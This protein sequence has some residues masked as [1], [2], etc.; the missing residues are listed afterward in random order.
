[1]QFSL[2]SADK[3]VECRVP[4]GF[5]LFNGICDAAPDGWAVASRPSPIVSSKPAGTGAFS[6]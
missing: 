6:R 5:V 4:E 1:V 3:K 2:H